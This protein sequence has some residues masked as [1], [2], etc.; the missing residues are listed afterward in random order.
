MQTD[1]HL[2]DEIERVVA[3]ALHE[4]RAREDVTSL[5]TM[6]ENLSGVAMFD[7]REPGIM[8]GGIVVAAVRGPRPSDLGGVTRC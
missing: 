6:D 7:A 5:A 3:L 2:Q 1:D 4:D 8:A